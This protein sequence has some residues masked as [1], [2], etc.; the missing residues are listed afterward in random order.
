MFKPAAAFRSLALSEGSGFWLAFRRPLFF[1][2]F[3]GCVISLLASTILIPGLVAGEML[4]WSV[5]SFLQIFS[6]LLI[7]GRRHVLSRGRT[8]DLFFAGMGP[9]LLWL[10]GLAALSSV[11]TGVVVQS[12]A[13]PPGIWRALGTMM[14]ILIWSGWIDFHFFRLVMG[15]SRSAAVRDLLLQRVIAWGGW[16]VLCYGY[17]AWPLLSWRLS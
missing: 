12:W 7:T 6:F 10:T 13:T 5:V 11:N 3:L 2:F 16:F 8:V 4:G 17:A 1:A 14:P 15:R 9:W